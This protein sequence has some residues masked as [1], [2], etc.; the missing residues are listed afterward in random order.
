MTVEEAIAEFRAGRMVVVVDS[1]DRENEGDVCVAASLVT[2][3]HVAFMAV[4]ARGLVCLAMAAERV[5]AL[6][7]P[8]MTEHNGCAHGTAFTVSIEAAS[9]VTTGISAADRAHTIRTAV[10]RRAEPSDLVMPGHV[11]PLRARPGGV[12]ERPGHTEA[13]SELA[14]LAGLEPAGV[15]CE[16]MNDDGTMARVPELREFCV[17]HDLALL[18]I[19]D[20]VAWKRE[21]EVSVT[22]VVETRLPTRHGEFRMVGYRGIDGDEHVALVLGDVDG[23]EDVLTR[24]HSSCI[25]G[26]AL[27]STRCDCGDQLDAA[28]AAIAEEGRGVLAYLDQEGRGIGLL[29][30]LRAYALQDTGLDTVDANLELGFEADPRSYRDAAAMLTDLGVRSVRLLTNNP[31]KL[32]ALPQHGVAVS[33]RVPIVMAPTDRSRGYLRTKRD[34]LGH[35]LRR[36]AVVVVDGVA[37]TDVFDAL[38]A[39]RPSDVE[40]SGRHA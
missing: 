14:A 27:G 29:N 25:T 18:S 36:P 19:E 35:L 32:A 6:G 4:H 33:G 20:L 11:F 17:E 39:G 3:A 23:G 12:L 13:A 21:R 5:D 7:L 22:R 8:P 10:A 40:A 31:R 16:I 9:G 37:C 1:E 26:D 28:L 38:E 30:K 2:D 24:V 15:I 34:R